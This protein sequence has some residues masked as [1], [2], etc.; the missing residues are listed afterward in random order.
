MLHGYSCVDERSV[1][2]VESYMDV[3]EVVEEHQKALARR[4]WSDKTMWTIRVY[5]IESIRVVGVWCRVMMGA[6]RRSWDYSE[7]Y[8][9]EDV[10]GGE[11]YWL[12]RWLVCQFG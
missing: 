10:V 5:R 12:L 11:K 4:D 2:R 6:V 9:D 1:A 8:G 7:D 3:V